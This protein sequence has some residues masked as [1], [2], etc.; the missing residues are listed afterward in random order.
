MNNRYLNRMKNYLM[1][2]WL[3]ILVAIPLSPFTG[4][5]EKYIFGDWEFLKFLVILMSVDTFLSVWFHIKK[6]DISLEGFQKI[7]IKV[8]CYGSALIVA[9][10]MGN[11]TV[12]G[13]LIPGFHW[14]RMVICTA[15]IVRE[16]LSIFKKIEKLYPGLLSPRIKRYLKYYDE[17]GE[18]PEEFV[19]QNK[20]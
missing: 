2:F 19:K 3:P 13:A 18:F 11:F 15:L 12:E 10:T 7:L 14:F 8:I 16:A 1:S 4:W 20:E 9:H 6:K 5:F 17:T